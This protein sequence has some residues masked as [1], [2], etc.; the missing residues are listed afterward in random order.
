MLRQY[1]D[2]RAAIKSLVEMP[3]QDTDRII[4]LLKERHRQVSNK[5]RKGLPQVFSE[6][7][8]LYARYEQIV[9]ALNLQLDFDRL[10]SL[11][12]ITS[13]RELKIHPRF[14]ATCFHLGR[15]K[16]IDGIL[17]LMCSIYSQVAVSFAS[18]N[19]SAQRAR[20][21]CTPQ[22]RAGMGTHTRQP[23]AHP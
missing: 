10:P 2:A 17:D 13:S 21:L 6:E 9:A 1:D 7:G 14:S 15:K 18:G 19:A 22:V 12:T 23:A 20:S 11:C 8:A 5:L 4:R 16:P 3:D